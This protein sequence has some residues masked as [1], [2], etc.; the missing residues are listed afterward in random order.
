MV[1]DHSSLM[2]DYKKPPTKNSVGV[3]SKT[4]KIQNRVDLE[5]H[6][7]RWKLPYAVSMHTKNILHL[8]SSVPITMLPFPAGIKKNIIRI[9]FN[10]EK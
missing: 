2:I 8:F 5:G 7:G 9:K 1:E 10:Y 3:N 4:K 6:Y